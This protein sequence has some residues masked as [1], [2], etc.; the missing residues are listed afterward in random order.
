[1][2]RVYERSY[3]YHARR[4]STSRS[5]ASLPRVVLGE[6]DVGELG[7]CLVDHD[8]RGGPADVDGGKLPGF[9]PSNAEEEQEL[10]P[11]PTVD[12]PSRRRWGL[13]A[14]TV[15]AG[16]SMISWTWLEVQGQSGGSTA[17]AP[18]PNFDPMEVSRIFFDDVF[19]K[20]QGERPAAGSAPVVASTSNAARPGG[21]AAAMPGGSAP[22]GDSGAG[23]SKLISTTTLEDEVKA[24]RL[25]LD[26]AVTTPSKFAGLGHK[27]ARRDF[28]LL[29]MLFAI[30]GEYDTEVRWKDQAPIARDV[31]ART[32]ANTKAG[33]N[34]NT[35]NE[36][37]RR[38]DDLQTLL[39]GSAITGDSSGPTVE[40]GTLVNV[41]PLMQRLEKAYDGNLAEWTS[42][43]EAFSS[44]LEEVVHEAELAAAIAEVI[45]KEGMD[46]ADDE[47]YLGFSKRLR[48]GALDIVAGVK[49]NNYDQARAAAGE[50]SKACSECHEQYR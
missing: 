7:V 41:G 32:A 5:E 20:L 8:S 34:T 22:T 10:M 31:F 6:V 4:L 47:T 44:H 18:A 27:D 25:N 30:V 21:A 42:S 26:Q 28:S 37:K 50:I 17:R 43:K 35:Y 29:A 23:W 14:A 1:M 19:T 12:R 9:F 46:N 11:T 36:A 33:G 16:A 38:K 48:Q 40:W 49:L 39:S 3:A 15:L 2:L 45:M 13:G 24:I